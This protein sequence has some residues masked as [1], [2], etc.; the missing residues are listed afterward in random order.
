MNNS[1]DYYL[2]LLFG[3][4]VELFEINLQ[5][6]NLINKIKEG[7]PIPFI[8]HGF[9]SVMEQFNK[10][11]VYCTNQSNALETVNLLK[12]TNPNFKDFIENVKNMQESRREDISSY[13][14]KPFQ[15]ITRYPLFLEQIIKY[16]SESRANQSLLIEVKSDVDNIVKKA[17]EAKRVFDSV[18][19]MIEVQSNFIWQGQVSLVHH[20]LGCFCF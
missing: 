6:Y 8:I 12:Q 5:F 20:F 10:Y 13:L 16:S 11:N 3:N 9:Q 4:V 17:N 19:K 18:V 1:S 7:D 15:R 2:P 14:T